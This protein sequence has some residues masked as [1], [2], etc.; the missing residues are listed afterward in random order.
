MIEEFVKE[1]IIDKLSES[2]RIDASLIN[3]ES[4][5]TDYGVD[6]IIAVNLIQTINKELNV[7]LETTSLFDF[8]TVNE[9]TTHILSGI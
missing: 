5:F 1:I 4:S 3:N 7:E 6:S 8:T 9:L 2:L